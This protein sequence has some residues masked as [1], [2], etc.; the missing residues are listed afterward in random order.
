MRPDE[1]HCRE[2]Y[3]FE[4]FIL[5]LY[6]LAAEA[7][8]KIQD[9]ELAL[10]KEKVIRNHLIRPEA[11]DHAFSEVLRDYRNHNDYES[12]EHIQ[13]CCRDLHL[14]KNARLKIYHDFQDIINADGVEENSERINLFKFRKMLG[15]ED[16]E[17]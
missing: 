5:Y 3:T 4:K 16:N 10:I 8:Y 2:D 1:N 9:E 13:N 12:L 15:I 7:D 17:I 14:D 11:F 6:L